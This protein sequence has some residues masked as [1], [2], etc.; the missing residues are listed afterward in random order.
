MALPVLIDGDV[1]RAYVRSVAALY[2]AR[3]RTRRSSCGS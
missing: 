3:R 2:T 1:V